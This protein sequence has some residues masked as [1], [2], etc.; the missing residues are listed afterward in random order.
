MPQNL[1][2]SIRRRRKWKLDT[3]GLALARPGARPTAAAAPAHADWRFPHAPQFPL[4]LHDQRARRARLSAPRLR[5]R[6]RAPLSRALPPDGQNLFDG[7]TSFILG[8]EWRVD[9]TAQELITAGEIEPLL[10]VGIYNAGERRI[11]EY[12]PTPDL[13]RPAGG[14]AAFTGAAST[15][16]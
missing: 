12:T 6:P 15:R 4:A 3:G 14:G 10:I 7:A 9:E 16:S 11:H 2:S 1:R 13:R 8:V 5:R